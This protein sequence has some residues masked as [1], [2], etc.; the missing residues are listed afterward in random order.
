M[1][2]RARSDVI[3]LARLTLG[4]H[5]PT[6][7]PLMKFTIPDD[8]EILAVFGTAVQHPLHIS[9]IAERLGLPL[10]ARRPLSE[11]LDAMA[12]RGLLAVLP[13]SRYRLPR[14][15]AAELQGRYSQNPR[16]FG[17]VTAE[18]GGP[19]VYIPATAMR[20]AMHGDRVAV[21]VQ[22][23]L[24]GREGVVTRVLVRRSP[25]VPGV[26]RIRPGGAWVE[27]DDLRIRGPIPVESIGS[28]KDG[29]AVVCEIVRWPEH[30][31]ELPQ[32]LV[33]ESLGRP[34]QL[35]VEVRKVLLREG[36]EED[37]PPEAIAEAE[38]LPARLA[39]DD[40]LGREDLR[41]LPLL[42]IDPP[43]ARDHDDA[44]YVRRR[45]GGG[46]VALIAIADV[47]HY[48]QPGTALDDA[49]RARGTSIYLPDRAIPMLPRQ[50]SSHL[51]SLVEGED[52]LTLAVEVHLSAQG[53]IEK[54]R[55]IEGV[56]R[57][58]AG[59]TYGNVAW[60]MGWSD[61]GKPSDQA[62]RFK[63]DLEVAAEL[64]G[65]L[66]TRR[67]RRG[68]LDFD[69]PEARVRFAEDGTTPIDIVQSRED[70]G[71]KRAYNLIEELMLLA[72][73]VIAQ[74]C[75]KR[76][77]P[78][79][80]RVHGAP[81]EDALVK[82]ATVARAYGFDIDPEDAAH[83]KKLAA[84]LRKIQG[85]PAA[86]VL[87]MVLLRSMPQ[88]VYHVENIGHFGLA[89]EAY[90]H[91]T[92]PIRRYP[93]I[94]AHRVARQVARKEKIRMDEQTL[95]AMRSVAVESSRLERRAMEIEREVMDLYRCVVAQSHIGE[96]HHGVVSGLSTSGPFVQ[97]ESPFIDVM[98]R[99]SDL[100]E[101][102][103]ELDDLGIRLH[104]ARSGLTFALGDP[105]IVEITDVSLS[106]RTVY[107]RM[108]EEERDALTI[109]RKRPRRSTRVA[110][111][112]EKPRTAP[113]R[114]GRPGKRE[115]AR[116]G[117]KSA[118]RKRGR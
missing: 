62:L 47:S 28:A 100:G 112:R 115:N 44:V 17:F 20:G 118:S 8:A 4:P 63:P 66:R 57:C 55:L 9:E 74:T 80:F 35:D 58:Q 72:N 48:V 70:P 40:Y 96:I 82:I 81:E 34:G 49:A 10:T 7:R 79:I 22:Q 36:V 71:I 18:D 12:A 6:I 99:T 14:R 37:F 116:T 31:G 85:T 52:R 42:T 54:S 1:Q 13:G 3:A 26:L 15:A 2:G 30:A 33:R 43:D 24:R 39:P 65:I 11:A 103:W 45:D 75:I 111:A 51:A 101:D 89:A 117:G 25:R 68:S 113:P 38:A 60:V 19:D 64:A 67:M 41:E 88:A 69:L 29:E 114:K 53:K 94:I 16:G 110:A 106:R 109:A 76:G 86:R 23:S 84:F 5:P 21:F 50:L 73:E 95:Q 56:M 46:Y 105:L 27:P 108:P 83:P 104:G 59:L 98:V 32:G 61:L 107:G 87:G 91:F 78:T 102:T 92:S 90:L 93:D 97:L 77:A